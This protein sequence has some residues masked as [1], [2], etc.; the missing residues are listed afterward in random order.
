[1]RTSVLGPALPT[2]V[3][4]P[5]DTSETM[6]ELLHAATRLILSAASAGALMPLP[7]LPPITTIHDEATRLW[8]EE[9]STPPASSGNLEATILA[10][11]RANYE[12]W[13]IEDAARAPG[14]SDAELART[15]R[16][17]DRVNQHRNDLTES[18]DTVLLGL[19]APHRLPHPEAE[20]HSESPGLMIDRLSILSLKLFH[21][22]E[23]LLRADAPPGHAARNAERLAILTAQRTDLKL[24]LERLWR[25]V[26]ASER[27]FKIYRQLKMYNDASLNPAVYRSRGEP[28]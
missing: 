27:S 26:L 14:F 11:H 24:A 3:R 15:K 16:A 17:I 22:R 20:L 4:L 18:C 6:P 13:H 10:Q 12:L 25:R 19:L 23:E 1:M 5:R 21:T 2:A 9:D 7:T 28:R 8:H